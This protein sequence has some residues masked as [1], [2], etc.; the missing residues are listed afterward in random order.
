VPR[1][2]PVAERAAHRERMLAT[3]EA[4]LAKIYHPDGRRAADR[5]R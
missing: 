3:I 1:N 4:E 2:F 5:L